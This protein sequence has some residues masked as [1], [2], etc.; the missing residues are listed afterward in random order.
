MNHEECKR[1][2]I[3]SAMENPADFFH[4]QFCMC[5]AFEGA[6]VSDEALKGNPAIMII[7]VDE[8]IELSVYTWERFEDYFRQEGRFAFSSTYSALQRTLFWDYAG[9][10]RTVSSKIS[11]DVEA[12][13]RERA[14]QEW[15]SLV[16][17]FISE[18]DDGEKYAWF[19]P[20]GL[21]ETIDGVGEVLY[22]SSKHTAK[23][24]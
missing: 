18:E 11:G 8:R 4:K 20:R 14:A 10:S 23:E 21:F 6:T 19:F 3:D 12:A 17:G 15:E 16:E 22:A 9:S 24:A 5:G 13:T 1:Y 2:I 7:T